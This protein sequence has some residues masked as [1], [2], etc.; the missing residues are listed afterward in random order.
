MAR[1]PGL[2]WHRSY[3]S[4]LRDILQLGCNFGASAP[5]PEAAMRIDGHMRRSMAR[6]S[7]VDKCK[8]CL[9]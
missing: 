2:C 8:D 4:I 3:E 7:L 6:A 9:Y 1:W 5:Q